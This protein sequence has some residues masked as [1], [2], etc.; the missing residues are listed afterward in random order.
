MSPIA[1]V[2]ARCKRNLRYWEPPPSELLDISLPSSTM[3]EKTAFDDLLDDLGG[4][5]RFQKRLLYFLLGP[6]FFI[7]PF[8]FLVQL[9]VV[10]SPDHWCRPQASIKHDALGLNLQDWKVGKELILYRPH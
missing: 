2:L 5:G 4:M 9:F 8:P 10:H 6:V 3:T 7:M 1:P